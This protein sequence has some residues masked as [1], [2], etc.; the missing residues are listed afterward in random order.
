MPFAYRHSA[1]CQFSLT[2]ELGISQIHTVLTTH[3]WPWCAARFPL[4]MTFGAWLRVLNPGHFQS[5]SRAEVEFG[6][7]SSF[8]AGSLSGPGQERWAHVAVPLEDSLQGGR[9]V[10]AL[11]GPTGSLILRPHAKS[12]GRAN[13][14]R[15][16]RFHWVGGLTGSAT[17]MSFI[18][19][20]R[21]R[22]VALLRRIGSS[23]GRPGCEADKP[24]TRVL[25]WQVGIFMKEPEPSCSKEG[26]WPS[27]SLF[28][29]PLWCR[30]LI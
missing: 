16:S 21:A 9:L 25:S 1:L 7:R 17:Q 19:A 3:S 2:V 6:Q 30:T 13:N 12:L 29:S 18:V 22:W 14:G 20:R 23:Q 27:S 4:S 15:R 26:K 24:R 5:V 11:L 28:E 8:A 10:F